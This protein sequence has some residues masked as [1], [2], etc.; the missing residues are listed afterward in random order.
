VP[1]AADCYQNR[2]A[3]VLLAGGLD[4]AGPVTL[5]PTATT[6]VTGMGGV[7][8]TQIVAQ[9][10]HPLWQDPAIDLSV[11]IAAVDRDAIVTSYAQAAYAVGQAADNGPATAARALLNWLS[12]TD[13]RWVVMLDDLQ[14]PD[15]IKGWW[16]PRV[17]TGHTLVTTRRR[18]A[19]LQRA[20]RRIIEIPAYTETE[21]LA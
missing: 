17:T 18:D 7:G 9:Y 5:V 16:P 4:R 21:S 2:D 13:R 10:I 1:L 15:D 19:A 3:S 8:K 14:D 11:W 12:T 6:V 20:D